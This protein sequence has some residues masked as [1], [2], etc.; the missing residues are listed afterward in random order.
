PGAGGTTVLRT[1]QESVGLEPFARRKMAH[2][3]I[4]N[5]LVFRVDRHVCERVRAG[6][7]PGAG[8]RPGP[9]AQ[10]EGGRAAQPSQGPGEPGADGMAA[11]DLGGT[12]RQAQDA[13]RA[14]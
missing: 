2:A 14:D 13:R 10:G 7:G 12:K 5:A 9:G 1:S 4:T 3:T 6:S 8:R 11:Q